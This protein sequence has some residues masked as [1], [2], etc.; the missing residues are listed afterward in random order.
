MQID[1][2]CDDVDDCVGEYDDC[3]VCNG[4]NADLDDCGVRFGNNEDQDC[5]GD[6]FETN[7]YR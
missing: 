3:G 6:C 4:E 7:C 5:N 2:I 1:G